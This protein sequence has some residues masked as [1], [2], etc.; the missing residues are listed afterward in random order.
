M[1]W[2]ADLPIKQKLLAGFAVMLLGQ[3]VLFCGA[4][5][6]LQGPQAAGDAAGQTLPQALV[7]SAVVAVALVIGWKALMIYLIATPLEALTKATQ[8]LADGDLKIAL[9]PLERKDE[10]GALNAALIQISLSQK[11][12][13][14]AARQ[15]ANG[16]LRASISARSEHDMVGGAFA[17]MVESMTSTNA[18]MRKAVTIV[19]TAVDEI[20]ASISQSASGATQTAAAV[21]QTT[22]T[23]EEVRQTSHLAS[24]KAEYVLRATEKTTQ[25]T[26][27]GR[28]ATEETISGMKRIRE[29]MNLIA[30]SMVKLSEKSQSIVEITQTVDD[31]SQQS[32]LL[33]VN[34]AIEAAKAGEFGKG[35]I[36]VAEEVKSMA[37]QSKQATGQVRNILTDIQRAISSVAMATELGS[38][39]VDS[40]VV[41]S[42]RAEESINALGH[43]VHEST[44]AATQIAVSSK[45]QLIGV[46]Q[47]ATAMIG[48]RDATHHNLDSINQVETA[49]LSLQ[50]LGAQLNALV[51]RY[52]L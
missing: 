31:L 11:A 22:T 7:V 2:L 33:A 46:D 12:M 42:S 21:T 32:N 47:I 18:Q 50:D 27:A 39:A 9:V 44:Q 23:V 41:Q 34:A 52:K 28:Q 13:T 19:N 8:S 30:E 49:V 25:I 43:S 37:D 24:Q 4:L 10:V 14:D 48:I 35:F 40:A 1:K 45:E 36:V 51:S 17:D 26:S 29:Q 16:D 5:L 38:K 6:S 3:I 20:M 15:L